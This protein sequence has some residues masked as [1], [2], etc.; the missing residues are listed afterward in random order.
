ML[1][2]VAGNQTTLWACTASVDSHYVLNPS[3]SPDYFANDTGI[4]VDETQYGWIQIASGLSSNGNRWE[5][6]GCGDWLVLNNGVDLPLTYRPGDMTA[7]P[8]YELREQQIASV[9][10]IAINS[11]N[12]MI[13][14]LWIINDDAFLALMA[15]TAGAVSASMTSAGVV[16]VA[17]A[18]LFP[19]TTVS[20]GQTLFWASGQAAKIISVAGGTITTAGAQAIP[21]GTVYL[22]NP[23]SYAAFTDQ[24]QMQRFPWRVVPSANGLPRRWGATLPVSAAAGSWQLTFA[25]PVRSLPEL[26]AYNNA[27]GYVSSNLI[28]GPTNVVI[29]YAG[30]GGTNLTTSVIGIQDGI[31]MACQLYLAVQNPISSGSTSQLQSSLQAADVNLGYAGTYVDLVDDGGRIIKMLDLLGQLV[32]YKETPVIFI[33]AFSGQVSAPYSYTR[34][35]LAN[36]GQ[37]LRFRNCILASGGGFYGSCHIYAGR[38]AFYKFDLF[39]QTPQEIPALTPAQD[40]FFLN[41]IADPENAFAAENPL[42]REWFFGWSAASGSVDRALC[43]DYAFQ[44]AR[45]TSAPGASCAKVQHPVRR[46]WMFIFGDDSGNVQQYGLLDAPVETPATVTVT[47]GSTTATASA[48]YWNVNHV[49]KT[50]W[51]ATG[52]LVAITGYVSPT[53][54]NIIGTAPNTTSATGFQVLP[55]IWHRNGAA[56]TSILETG[57]GDLDIADSEKQVNRYVLL[58]SSK[59]PN[60]TITALFKSGINPG[61]PVYG[62]SA[63]IASPQTAHNLIEPTFINYHVG[64]QLSIAGINN[65]FG[66]VKQIWDVLP[67]GSKSAGRI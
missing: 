56:Y 15:P 39:M 49:G 55:G 41:A 45:T 19:G 37:A 63:T 7:L 40:I 48:A 20:V 2:V 4:Y 36:E 10:T 43:W 8:I 32:V 58:A 65:P 34:I 14:D 25:Y 11:G 62:P 3:G 50:L 42:T 26:V 27:G 35:L 16:S 5:A 24:T 52:D 54:V 29:L 22:E 13:A 53:V 1:V 18:T 47:I 31:A 66:L 59:S 44:T 46:D 30:L 21:A 23:A 64:V 61:E 28:G 60:S 51:L 6:V 17:A 9:G 12:L 38:N 33:G 67:V 57:M